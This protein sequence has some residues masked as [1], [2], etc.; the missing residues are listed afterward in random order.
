MQP[1][2]DCPA[3]ACLHVS[4]I[5]GPIG[6]VPASGMVPMSKLGDESFDDAPLVSPGPL[7]IVPSDMPP[8][9]PMPIDVSDPIDVYE[10]DSRLSGFPQA[11]SAMNAMHEI[12]RISTPAA[13]IVP[14]S[15]ATRVR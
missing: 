3:S 4:G 7:P 9:V 15:G 2:D 11:P 1:T 8:S 12:R 6:S 14:R 13:A 5:T 10:P